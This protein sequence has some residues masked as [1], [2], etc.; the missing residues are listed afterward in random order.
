MKRTVLLS[1][2]G[3]QTIVKK[4]YKYY[5]NNKRITS[6]KIN[7]TLLTSMLSIYMYINKIIF[8]C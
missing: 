5:Y 6:N 3:N 2:E 8:R 1:A 7:N 4:Y